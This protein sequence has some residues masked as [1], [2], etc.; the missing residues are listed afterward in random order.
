MSCSLLLNIRAA[1][2]NAHRA[3][4]YPMGPIYNVHEKSLTPLFRD[5][6][7]RIFTLCDRDGD[8]VLG[9]A[10]IQFFNHATF[11]QDLPSKDL[12]HVKR[13][14]CYSNPAY[15]DSTRGDAVRFEGFCFW[16]TVFAEKHEEEVPW[17]VAYAWGYG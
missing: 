4:V 16:L 14:A 10:D 13:I 5:R 8:G 6:L 17:Q 12:E 15:V 7:K 9:D 1:L 11:E 3:V 2:L